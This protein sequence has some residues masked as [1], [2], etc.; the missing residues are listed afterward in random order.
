[1]N[2]LIFMNSILPVKKYGGTQRIMWWLA[3]EYNNLGHKVT[4]LSKKGTI[5]SF[6]DV[7]FYNPE[8]K[9]NEQIPENID[10]IHFNS[11]PKE[12]ITK[13]FIVSIRG[14]GRKG[15]KFLKN[16]V[17]LS[18]NH[19]E[20]H[21]SNCFVYN[22]LDFNDYGKPNFNKKREHLLFLAKASWR[23]KNLAGVID[24]SKKSSQKLAVVGG[25]R[26]NLKMGFRF[27]PNLNV[28]FYGLV[29][30]DK[31]NEILN[32]STALL[33]PVLWHEPFGIAIIEAMYF[34]MP[35][36]GTTYGSLPEIITKEVGFLSNNKSE[37]TSE[38]KNIEKYNRTNCYEY[39]CDNFN[40]QI[41]AKGYLKFYEKI[42]NN[43]ILNNIAPFSNNDY[44]KKILEFNH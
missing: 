9:I 18:K 27:T 21:N 25:N 20:R 40:S 12:E 22:G 16:T 3:K 35:V 17:F 39:V 11:T 33:F 31:K 29:G 7:I 14:N 8:K 44:N 41:M 30:G 37:I 4:F 42:L 19:A 23:V 6:A 1:M 5:C 24:I 36:F 28:K 10:I 2:I 43:E 26:L 32:K 13:P 15:E 38:I 34:G